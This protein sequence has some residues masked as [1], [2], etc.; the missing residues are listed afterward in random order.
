MRELRRKNTALC[1]IELY[2]NDLLTVPLQRGCT[3]LSQSM[4]TL[5]YDVVLNFLVRESYTPFDLFSLSKPLLDYQG[6]H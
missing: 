3:K 2:S 5:S 1:S 4:Q 6:R